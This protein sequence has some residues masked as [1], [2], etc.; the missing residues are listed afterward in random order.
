MAGLPPLR[1]PL[2]PLHPAL[3]H[4]QPLLPQVSLALPTPSV[5]RG[6]C[7][8]KP[9]STMVCTDQCCVRQQ[10]LKCS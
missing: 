9:A 5:S 2:P 8:P 6:A 4:L 3:V 7:P 10:P 1:R